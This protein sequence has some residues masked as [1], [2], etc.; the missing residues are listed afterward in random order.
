MADEEYLLNKRFINKNVYTIQE[1]IPSYLKE[2]E[3]FRQFMENQDLDYDDINEE[4]D[5]DE[6]LLRHEIPLNIKFSTE[7]KKMK[8]AKQKKQQQNSLG[9][10]LAPP[11]QQNSLGMTLAP[12]KQKKKDFSRFVVEKRHLLYIDSRDR[13]T[14]KYTEPNYYKIYLKRAYTNVVAIKL[15]SS[16]FTNTQQL[17]RSTPTSLKNNVIIWKIDGDGEDT[18]YSITL[19]P[20]NYSATTLQALIQNAMNSVKRVNGKYNNITVSIDI[21]TDIVKLS[22]IDFETLSNPFSFG[23]GLNNQTTITISHANHGMNMGESVYITEGISIGG[24][25]QSIWNATHTVSY[26]IDSNSYQIV[27]NSSATSIET[28][29]GGTSV[30]IGKGLKFKL[31]FSDPNSPYE[32][33]GFQNIDTEYN[34]IQS[35]SIESFSYLEQTTLDENGQP[36]EST[37]Q[38]VAIPDGLK[39]AYILYPKVTNINGYV[40]FSIKKIFAPTSSSESS[41]Y[42]YVRTNYDHL[43]ETGDEIFIFK[44][45]STMYEKLTIFDHLYGYTSGN[46]NG[47]E[48][49]VLTQGQE[50]TRA[51]FIEEVCNPAGLL[52]T[53]VDANTFKIPVPYVG[54]IPIETWISNE[55]DT[56]TDA[57]IEYGSIVK[58][59]VNQ[60]LNLSGE[61]YIFM[62]SN[63]IGT[64]ETSGKVSNI[65]AKIQLA[66]ASGADIFNAYIG[67]YQ[68]YT[69][70]PLSQLREIDFR[71]YKNDGKLF[72]FYDNDHSF[73]LEITEAIQKIDGVG[74]SSKI[75]TTT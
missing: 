24:I 53:I 58:T 4:N 37:T 2:Q 44:S 52:V 10:P 46:I 69:D 16:E 35:N 54:I 5:I 15:K 47:V 34:V 17:I 26:I 65:F 43:L 60:S 19:T 22:S 51:G 25:D 20:G 61:K 56:Q 1:D 45:S 48:Y 41:I 27:V 18:S 63:M 59:K 55:V 23:I 74:F 67:G 3:E 71:F 75:G 40:R 30:K 6:D 66:S 11:K 57:S 32:L 31:I 42:S 73:T 12:P 8:T 7:E 36:I 21:V 14:T 33:L 68:I 70:T 72:E 9:M 38:V 49:P 29:V 28:N 50:E 39:D 64:G 62:Q 13:D